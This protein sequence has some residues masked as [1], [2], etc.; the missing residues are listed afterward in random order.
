M[1]KQKYPRIS[2]QRKLKKVPMC[3]CGEIA[4]YLVTIQINNFRGDDEVEYACE[5]HR[6]DMEFLRGVSND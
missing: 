2:D 5:S 6:R 1:T 4:R 3:K